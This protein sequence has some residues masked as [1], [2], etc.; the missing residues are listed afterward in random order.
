MR[1]DL[2]GQVADIGQ[3]QQAVRPGEYVGAYFYDDSVKHFL[4]T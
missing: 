2:I 1:G 3:V 4:E